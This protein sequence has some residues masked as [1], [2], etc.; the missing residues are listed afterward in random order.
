MIQPLRLIYAVDIPKFI[1]EHTH[2][3]SVVRKL[4]HTE[5]VIILYNAVVLAR[6]VLIYF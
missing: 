5:R 6:P 4:M 3:H 2:E 1:N